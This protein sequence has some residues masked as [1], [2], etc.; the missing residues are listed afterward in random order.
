M[1]VTVDA[2]VTVAV[3]YPDMLAVVVAV[4]VAVVEPDVEGE[5]ATEVVAVDVSEEWAVMDIEE[6]IVVVGV[7]V[8]VDVAVMPYFSSVTYVA[9]LA[10]L[11]L[12]SSM[13]TTTDT[14]LPYCGNVTSIRVGNRTQL[15]V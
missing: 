14:F 13:S 6:V 15:D 8:S 9:Q 3:E 2:R 11:P 4:D 10:R 7:V 12:R 5:V 1:V